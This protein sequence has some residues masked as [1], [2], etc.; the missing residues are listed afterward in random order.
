MDEGQD[1]ISEF[2]MYYGKIYLGVK[3]HEFIK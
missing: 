2:Y 1:C 3:N